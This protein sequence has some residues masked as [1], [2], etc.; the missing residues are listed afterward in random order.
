MED[1]VGN[2]LDEFY[3]NYRDSLK[4]VYDTTRQ[5]LEQQRRNSFTSIMSNANKAGM[6]YSNFPTR[7][8]LKYDVE[9]YQPAQIKTQQTYQSGLDTLRENA[10]KAV[11]NITS[12]QEQIAHLN[13]LSK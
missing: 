8:K 12:L 2:N 7:D 11:N 9:T 5:Q 4:N 1:L 6:M 13:S 3:R 10:L